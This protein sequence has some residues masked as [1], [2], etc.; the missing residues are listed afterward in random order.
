MNGRGNGSAEGARTPLN[1]PKS[2]PRCSKPHPT[3]GT[4]SFCG[5]GQVLEWL[6][7]RSRWGSCSPCRPHL[8]END[9]VEEIQRFRLRSGRGVLDRRSPKLGGKRHQRAVSPASCD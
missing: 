6:S 4:K 8:D 9:A 3:I 1:S 5:K 2:A 7:N